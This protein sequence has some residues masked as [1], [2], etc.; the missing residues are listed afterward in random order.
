MEIIAFIKQRYSMNKRDIDAYKRTHT[1][2]YTHKNAC[3]NN[4]HRYTRVIQ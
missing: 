1:H 2:S 4:T 3:T